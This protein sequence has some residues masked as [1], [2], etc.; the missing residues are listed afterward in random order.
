MNTT[1]ELM[2]RDIK[3]EVHAVCTYIY[4]KERNLT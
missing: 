3:K 4:P 2:W 1:K